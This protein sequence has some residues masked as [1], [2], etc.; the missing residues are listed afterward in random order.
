M[1]FISLGPQCSRGRIDRCQRRTAVEGLDVRRG[2]VCDELWLRAA[3]LLAE[4]DL[5]SVV[6][7]SDRQSI[8][9]GCRGVDKTMTRRSGIALRTQDD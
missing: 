7:Y 8:D 5:A 4:P 1:S 3:L 6:Q 2:V 9:C